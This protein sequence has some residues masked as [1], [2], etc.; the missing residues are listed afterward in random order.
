MLHLTRTKYALF[1]NAHSVFSEI[2][3]YI[4]HKQLKSIKI[5]QNIFSDHN[6]IK[7]EINNNIFGRTANIWKINDTVLNNS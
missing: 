2:D 5:M 4:G 1:S 3:L 6:R 7:S